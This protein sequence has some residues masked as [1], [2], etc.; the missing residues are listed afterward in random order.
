MKIINST[1]YFFA[2]TLIL[3][4]T[5]CTEYPL[6]QEPETERFNQTVASQ[7]L[8][9][10]LVAGKLTPG[11]PYFV[12]SELFSS[13]TPGIMETK[14]PVASL[15]S[16]Q[17]LEEVEGWRRV[18]VDPDTKVLLDKY[19]TEKGKLY[20]WYQRP[21]FYT[22]DVS[23]RDTLCIFVEDNEICS[24]I[25]NLNSSVVLTIRDSLPQV[26]G[27]KNIY[28]EIRYNDHPW[29]VTSYWYDLKMFSNGRTFKIKDVN[30]ETYPIELLEFNDEPVSSF[31]WR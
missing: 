25:E 10:S 30:F 1:I 5:N 20:V 23:R 15:G 17:R 11:M 8:K 22:M 4:L 18:Y 27:S 14:I 12:A 31:K 28:A 16:K 2:L 19:E 7:Q 13:W 21:D 3:F 29:R 26:P 9:D 6:I 24:V